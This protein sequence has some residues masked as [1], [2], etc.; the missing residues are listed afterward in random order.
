MR[1]EVFDRSSFP[2]RGAGSIPAPPTF[3]VLPEV[4]VTETAIQGR[5]PARLAVPLYPRCLGG[6]APRPVP[7]RPEPGRRSAGDPL[8]ADRGPGAPLPDPLGGAQPGVHFGL[9]RDLYHG[10]LPL[11]VGAGPGTGRRGARLRRLGLPQAGQ[12]HVCSEA[13]QDPY[14]P[15]PPGPEHPQAPAFSKCVGHWREWS[16]QNSK[17]CKTQYFGG[18]YQ[19]CNYRSEI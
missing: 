5:Q 6:P 11:P 4:I 12:R 14:S 8:Q 2:L 19:L 18:K 13:K 3:C 9:H 16:G 7:G 1:Q 17:L 10:R 15:R